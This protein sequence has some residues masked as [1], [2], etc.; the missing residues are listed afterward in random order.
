MSSDESDIDSDIESEDTEETEDDIVQA[1]IE[2]SDQ[3]DADS[4]FEEDGD[5][6]VNVSARALTNLL[7]TPIVIP[8]FKPGVPGSVITPFKAAAPVTLTGEQ[9]AQIRSL[10]ISTQA[11][12]QVPVQAPVQVPV[13][14]PV[15]VPVPQ[16]LPLTPMGFTPAS[17]IPTII[18]AGGAPITPSLTFVPRP[19]TSPKKQESK[20][21]LFNKS[22]LDKNLRMED[23]TN[24]FKK[25]NIGGYTKAKTKGDRIDLMLK[26]PLTD[27]I[28]LEVSKGKVD[29]LVTI[30]P[31][32][33]TFPA[34][35]TAPTAPTAPTV[36]Q[37]FT[38]INP[39]APTVPT[40]PT[41]PE[42]YAEPIT[43]E[44]GS[45]ILQSIEI[46][47]TVLVETPTIQTLLSKYPT[48]TKE[49][50]AI[51]SIISLDAI[52][53]VGVTP[54]L[55]ANTGNIVANQTLLG[56]SYTQSTISKKE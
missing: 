51:R 16:M 39:A 26:Y 40:V 6:D 41:F 21:V 8:S 54:Q 9:L 5:T 12:V 38:S 50:H 34:V 33:Q 2:P 31:E 36:P 23:I 14:A 19:R 29:E 46:A 45:E 4:E 55:A 30:I 44:P 43:V 11:P 18:T 56:V 35:P 52:R 37:L 15:Q 24:L 28:M 10:P 53:T 3:T 20:T 48:E 47:P 25:R 42:G 32:S 49:H 27:P 13:Q 17:T 1:Y 7:S 22:D